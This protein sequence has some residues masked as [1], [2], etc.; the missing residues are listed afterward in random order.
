MTETVSWAAQGIDRETF[1]SYMKTRDGSQ[2]CPACGATENV[3][4]DFVGKVGLL[5]CNC[6]GAQGEYNFGITC[7]VRPFTK[8]DLEI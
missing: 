1:D 8:G 3:D 4:F 7:T 5:V 6:C 2:Y